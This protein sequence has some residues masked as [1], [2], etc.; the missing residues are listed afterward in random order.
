MSIKSHQPPRPPARQQRSHIFDFWRGR[1]S[2]PSRSL[3][4]SAFSLHCSSQ[5]PTSGLYHSRPGDFDGIPSSWPVGPLQ[6][7]PRLVEAPDILA[8]SSSTLTRRMDAEHMALIGAGRQLCED[9]K[10]VFDH[11]Y[12][13]PL[14]RSVRVYFC[15]RIHIFITAGL[16]FGIGILSLR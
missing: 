4:S 6:T 7:Q 1:T 10:G 11:L 8:C 13:K 3:P 16:T 15:P 9:R 12:P 14:F 2:P 5:I